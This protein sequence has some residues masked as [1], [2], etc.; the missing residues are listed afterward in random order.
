MY[1]KSYKS[2]KR[3]VSNNLVLKSTLRT[4]DKYASLLEVLPAGYAKTN[5]KKGAAVA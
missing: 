3:E 2:W 4:V 1:V 5:C